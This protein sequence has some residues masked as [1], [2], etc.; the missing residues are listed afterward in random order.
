MGKVQA[1]N[2]EQIANGGYSPVVQV[3]SAEEKC[4]KFTLPG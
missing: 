1:R 3:V 2:I 4:K